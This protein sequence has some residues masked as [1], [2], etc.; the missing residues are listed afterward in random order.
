LSEAIK[1]MQK[2]RIQHLVIVSDQPPN[3]RVVGIL[4]AVDLVKFMGRS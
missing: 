3:K 1:L 2:M 4:A